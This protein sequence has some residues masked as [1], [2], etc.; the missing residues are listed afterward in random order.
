MKTASIGFVVAV[1]VAAFAAGG[2]STE[3]YCFSDCEG[4]VDGG[5]AANGG[6]GGASEGGL[7]NYIPVGGSGGSTGGSGGSGPCVPTGSE[8]CDGIDND[9]NGQIDEIFNLANDPRNCGVCGNDCTLVVLGAEHATCTATPGTPGTCGYDSCSTD[10]WDIDGDPSNG[11]EYYCVKKGDTDLTCDNIDDNCNKR[12]DEQ[13]DLCS[14][15][16]NCGK[17]GR[18]CQGKPHAVGKCVAS[19]SPTTCDET[20][21]QCVLDHCDPGFIDPNDGLYTMW[22]DANGQFADGC[23]Y[24]CKPSKRTDPNDPST[25]VHCDPT[26]DPDCGKREYCDGED[27]D[28]N[29]KIDGADPNLTNATAGD[30]AVNKECHGA[31]LGECNTDA[32]KGITRCIAATIKCTNDNTGTTGCNTD[33]DCTDPAAPAC[34]DSPNPPAKVCGTRVIKLND[35]PETCNGK[36]DDCDGVVDDSPSDA[37]GKCGNNVGSCVQGSYVCQNG[38]LACVGAITPQAETCNGADDDCDGVVDGTAA[39]PEVTCT[40]DT[41]CGGQATAK[42]CLPK[43][44]SPNKVCA[45]LPGDIVD[46]SNA[47]IPCDVPP[48]PPAGWTT[49]CKAGQLACVGGAKVC[50]GSVKKSANQDVCGEDRNCD[51][52]KS[53]DFNTQTDVHN[54]GACGSDCFLTQGGH[55][56]W[57]CVAGHCTAPSTNKCQPGY[58]DCDADP[59]TCER[60]CTFQSNQELCNGVDDNCNCQVDENVTAPSPTQVCGVG[61]AATGVCVGGPGGV[62]VTCDAGTWKCTFPAGYCD[63]GTPPSCASTPDICD[64]KDNNCNGNTDENFKPPVLTQGYLGQ[65]CYSD[66]GL[67]TKHGKCQ[68][69]GT[70]KCDGKSST[71]CFNASNQKIAGVPADCNTLPGGCTE[72]CNGIDDDCDGTIDETFVSKGSNAT[73]FVKPAVVKLDSANVWMYRYEAS[74]PSATTTSPGSGNGWWRTT[75]QTNQPNAPANTPLDKT[76]S[77]S[78]ANKVPWFNI[79][80]LEAQ[81]V[82]REMG[83]R[84]CRNSEWQTGCRSSTNG[85][86]WGFATNCTTFNT[87]TN[88]TTCNLAPYDFVPGGTDQD[89]LLPTGFLSGCRAAWG[90]TTLSLYDITGNLRELTCP[91][92][93]AC[94]ATQ[95]SFVLMGGAFNTSDPTGEGAKCSFSFYNVDNTFKLFDVGF[96]CCFDADPTQ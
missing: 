20:N 84:L 46:S 60:P 43:T 89:G 80:G 6:S 66:D 28:C 55:V 14:D 29:G 75:G 52:L 49:P 70:Y 32:H 12:Y 26:S 35:V 91:G 79:T 69:S 94:T 81:H 63:K 83:G 1:W 8:I 65:V 44:G 47:R 7:D 87:T 48:D 72:E 61:P 23:E 24:R 90:S 22:V 73:Y 67:P 19:G 76:P 74:R 68:Q 2:C 3:S 15:A 13:V 31:A 39:V 25:L 53:P 40:T 16:N 17:C 77:C 82:C 9:C 88:W 59:N 18:N 11:C 5:A 71:A 41:N 36:D 92:S 51:G 38:A 50:E 95:S 64:G 85:C 27:N 45:T 34:V 42:W 54:C 56:N 86:Y 78:V 62:Q 37:G 4:T 33:A 96:R 58:I 30:P 10:F 21:T 93:T 57:T